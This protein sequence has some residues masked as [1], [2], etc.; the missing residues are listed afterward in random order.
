MSLFLPPIFLLSLVF[1]PRHRYVHFSLPAAALLVYLVY[2]PFFDFWDE[3]RNQGSVFWYVGPLL[4]L[5]FIMRYV[6]RRLLYKS[7][8]VLNFLATVPCFFFMVCAIY[9]VFFVL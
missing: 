6:N 7:L 4:L 3:G 5:T 2:P 9:M 1:N 8:L